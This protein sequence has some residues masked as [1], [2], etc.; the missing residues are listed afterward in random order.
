MQ[1]ISGE[2]AKIWQMATDAKKLYKRAM[3]L[4]PRERAE[5]AGML[6]ESLEI[7]GDDGVELAWLEEI[8]KRLE[9]VDSET[10]EMTPWSEV[11]ARVFG[12]RGC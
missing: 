4:D 1:I 9:T 8:E 11:R 10:V 3:D 7:G 12:P 5:L 6:L 2:N